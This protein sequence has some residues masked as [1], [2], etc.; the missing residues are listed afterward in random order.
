M[1]LER[2]RLQLRMELHAEKPGMVFVFD[3]LRQDPVGRHSGKTHAALFEASLIRSVDFVTAAMT[4][5]N[6]GCPIYL[7]HTT[8]AREH[9]IVGAEPHG[10]AALAAPAPFLRLIALEPLRHQADDRLGCRAEFCRVCVLDAT[11]IARG[12]EYRHLHSA[13]NPDL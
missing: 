5:R 3:D 13:A 12:L 1:R 11:Q 6:F 9:C 8:A 10:A 2:P 7:R 4:F